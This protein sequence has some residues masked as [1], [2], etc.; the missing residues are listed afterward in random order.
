MVTPRLIRA[1][2]ACKLCSSYGEEAVEP[3]PDADHNK[4]LYLLRAVKE[5]ATDQAMF[6][7]MRSLEG[8]NYASL[9]EKCLDCYYKK[10]LIANALEKEMADLKKPKKS[11]GK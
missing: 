11:S 8:T 7:A 5:I 4:H 3:I 10:P 2:K 6:E 1:Y 9:A